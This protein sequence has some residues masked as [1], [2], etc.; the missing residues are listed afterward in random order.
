MPCSNQ[1][2]ESLLRCSRIFWP[3]SYGGTEFIFSWPVNH[4]AQR[5]AESVLQKLKW[6]L[7]GSSMQVLLN[8]K[9]LIF[10]VKQRKRN[11]PD[12][13]TP[14][15]PA[16]PQFP[17][18]LPKPLN[19]GLIGDWCLLKTLFSAKEYPAFNTTC[20]CSWPYLDIQKTQTKGK[21][22]GQGGQGTQTLCKKSISSSGCAREL[23][24]CYTMIYPSLIIHPISRTCPLFFL[25]TCCSHC[26]PMTL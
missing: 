7:Q 24:W 26:C 13:L 10:L 4:A 18:L 15:S 17:G 20:S 8:S 6:K 22:R 9:T 12:L 11:L 2:N 16:H 25:L 3:C 19:G 23:V 5:H 14:S 1:H 21:P